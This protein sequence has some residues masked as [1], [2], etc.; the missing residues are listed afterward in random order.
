MSSLYPSMI[1]YPAE[2]GGTLDTLLSRNQPGAPFI[3]V[4]VK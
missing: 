1:A 4:L 3:G 2:K